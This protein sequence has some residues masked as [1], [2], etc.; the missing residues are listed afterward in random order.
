MSRFLFTALTAFVVFTILLLTAF[1]LLVASV[2]AAEAQD[3]RHCAPRDQVIERLMGKYGEAP[4]ALGIAAN[5]SVLEVFASEDTGTWTITV[6]MANG[7]TC[8]IASGDAFERLPGVGLPK[9]DPL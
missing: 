6:T 9:G 4:Q 3:L 1:G 5:N 2:G 8:L 7:V